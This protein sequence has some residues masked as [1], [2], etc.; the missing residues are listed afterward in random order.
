MSEIGHNAPA[1][2]THAMHID[3]LFDE[4]KGFIDGE[5]IANEGQAE[6]VAKLLS[7]IRQA[8]NAA[9]ESR[10]A[11]KKPHDDAAKAVQTAYAPLLAKCDLAAG[12]CK[13]TLTPWQVK[14][15]AEQRAIAQAAEDK[16]ERLRIL[17]LEAATEAR[18]GGDL[19]SRA[20]AE[21]ALK[22]AEIASK[23]VGKLSKAKPLIAGGARAVTLIDIWTPEI[24]DRRAALS[25]Y[26][27]VQPD[28]LTE[29]LMDQAKRDVA[30]GSRTIPGFTIKHDRTSR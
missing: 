7:A 25:H 27:T 17:A 18:G 16:A 23:E 11:E 22:A 1:S 19:Q 24:T 8:R 12:A 10:K 14:K 30:A 29:W 5:P 4:A 13:D 2:I 3:D 20:D 26:M 28:A 15:E 21:D 6:A 9:D